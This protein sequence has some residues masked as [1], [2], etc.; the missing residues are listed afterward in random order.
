MG[1]AWQYGPRSPGAISRFLV[2][3]PPPKRLPYLE[4]LHRRM[5]MRFRR[6]L[7]RV[8][9]LAAPPPRRNETGDR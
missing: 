9:T 7:G 3:E 2:P 1:L 8:T 6:N 5:R 4:R